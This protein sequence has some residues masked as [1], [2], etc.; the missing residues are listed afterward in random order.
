MRM[1]SL[2]GPAHVSGAADWHVVDSHRG[3]ILARRLLANSGVRCMHS[4]GSPPCGSEC[5]CP[6][7]MLLQRREGQSAAGDRV[8]G[9]FP[10]RWQKS[11]QH[12]R[13][14]GT[15]T[16]S[17]CRGVVR[18]VYVLAGPRHGA[19]VSTERPDI[20][21]DPCGDVFCAE[22]GRAG[23][24]CCHSDHDTRHLSQG[25][26]RWVRQPSAGNRL[27]WARIIL[28][29]LQHAQSVHRCSSVSQD[30][31]SIAQLASSLC[32][33]RALL[34]SAC[35]MQVSVTP[36]HLSVWCIN[37]PNAHNALAS[38]AQYKSYTVTRFACTAGCRPYTSR[39]HPTRQ[40]S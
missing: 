31:K 33:I 34:L 15:R 16:S 11:S 30:N 27:C 37:T 40:A 9:A 36:T 19:A 6:A 4:R 3:L 39:P 18:A 5:S 22:H 10:R 32:G 21:S 20:T 29:G 38:G 8:G 14:P 35:S 12:A 17:V 28:F 23:G 13:A 25:A 26:S 1:D 24:W 2:S 7:S